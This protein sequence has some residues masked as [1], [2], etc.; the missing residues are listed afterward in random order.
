MLSTK[1]SVLLVTGLM[2]LLSFGCAKAGLPDTSTIAHVQSPNGNVEVTVTLDR[3]GRPHY[4]VYLGGRTLLQPSPL[5]LA[6]TLGRWTRNLDVDSVGTVE[7]VE[8]HYQLHHGKCSSCRYEARRRVVHLANS[9][10]DVLDIIFQV[11]NDGVAFRYRIPNRS[12]TPTG[13]VDRDLS[14]FQFAPETSSWLTPLRDPSQGWNQTA[15]SYEAHYVKDQPVGEASPTGAGWAFPALFRRPGVG[16]ALVTEAGLKGSYHG[17]R[18]D[19]RSDGLYRV[20]GPEPEEGTGRGDP[21]V[22]SISLP[23]TSP[24]RLVIV[25]SDLGPIVESTLVTDVSPPSTLADPDFVEPGTVAWSWLPL[26]DESIVPDV[27]RAFIDMA[28]RYGFEYCLIDNWWDQKIGYEKAQKLVNYAES[29]GVGIFLWYNSNG[30]F[31]E[32]PQTPQDRMYDAQVRQEE[33]QRL[34]EMGVR[35]VKV[36]FFGG[37]KQSV[38]QFYLDLFRDAGTHD[39]MVNVHGSTLP[40][41]WRRTYPQFMTSEAVRGYEFI[42]FDQ[43]DA[44]EAPT[45]ATML[46]FTRNVAGPMDFTPTMLTDTVG[47]SKRKTRNA[48]DLAMAVVFESGLQHLGVTPESLRRQPSFVREFLGTLPAAWDDIHFIDGHPGRFVVLARRTG[49]TWYLAGFNGSADSRTVQVPLT[50]MET[51]TVGTLLTDGTDLRSLEHRS[52]S[53]SPS[54]SLSLELRGRGGFVGRFPPAPDSE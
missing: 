4:S 45:H 30:P 6:T 32:A 51:S 25:G 46:P 40:R 27:Q 33:F 11:S 20:R 19:A 34:Q 5:G 35:G 23:F 42:T 28:A 29:K 53:V 43:A 15:P 22:P 18:L 1:D 8:E 38:I 37:D 47:A 21:V 9:E 24:W 50:F 49:D 14:G 3:E 48:F 13:H 39:L 2:L 52:V 31:N 16:W 26:K 54:D 7:S 36:D 12:G 41:G 10:G 17:S 44:D